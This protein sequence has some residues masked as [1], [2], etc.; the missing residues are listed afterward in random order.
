MPSVSWNDAFQTRSELPASATAS[1]SLS[2]AVATHASAARRL[3]SSAAAT[4]KPA[5]VAP[6]S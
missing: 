4:C 1:S 3:S 2:A 5:A 6:V